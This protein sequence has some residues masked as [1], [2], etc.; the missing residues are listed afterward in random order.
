MKHIAIR[1]LAGA[2]TVAC[3]RH[4]PPIDKQQTAIGGWRPGSRRAP[5]DGHQGV[6]MA[7]A[8]E[9]P[10]IQRDHEGRSVI[11][12]DDGRAQERPEQSARYG[13]LAAPR[14]SIACKAQLGRELS[15]C[16]SGHKARRGPSENNRILARADV[17]SSLF[18]IHNRHILFP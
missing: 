18:Q 10:S 16:L 6:V 3:Q 11:V 4:Q 13:S 5:G 15:K 1:P 14:P 9:A 8:Q 12:R 7:G 2:Y 17:P